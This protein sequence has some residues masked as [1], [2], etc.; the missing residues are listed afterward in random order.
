MMVKHRHVHPHPRICCHVQQISPLLNPCW[1]PAGHDS[2]KLRMQQH[3][4]AVQ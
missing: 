1:R 4:T 3:H 2:C